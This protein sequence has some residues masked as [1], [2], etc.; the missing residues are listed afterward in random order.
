[1]HLFL[2]KTHS[3]KWKRNREKK[4][5]Q[6][7]IYIQPH[8]THDTPYQDIRFQNTKL[9]TEIYKSVTTPHPPKCPRIYSNSFVHYFSL[10][11]NDPCYS[12]DRKIRCHN[13]NR[14]FRLLTEAGV[15]RL[16]DKILLKTNWFQRTHCVFSQ[17]ASVLQVP[18]SVK[19][20][21]SWSQLLYYN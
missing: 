2:L 7:P 19:K 12:G 1:M 10:L 13:T 6:R 11:K 9:L 3:P 15:D 17:D 4:G 18:C 14:Q 16:Q 20:W 5:I 21:F 8:H